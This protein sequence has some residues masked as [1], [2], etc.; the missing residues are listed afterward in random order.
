MFDW[1]TAAISSAGY[2]GVLFAMFLE[3]VFPPIPSELV[4]LFSGASAGR[5]ELNVILVFISALLGSL[6]GLL[7]WYY[8]ARWYGARRMASFA[9]RHGR[10]LTF[11][12]G[13]VRA[14]NEWFSKYGKVTVVIARF[15]PAIR[16]I[17]AVPAAVADMKILTFLCYALVGSI[18]YDGAFYV[19]GYLLGEDQAL[20]SW[21]NLGTAIVL[22]AVVIWYVYRV[23]TYKADPPQFS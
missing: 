1:I 17:I 18:V 4:M 3:N 12:G 21:I 13:E 22:L 11:T 20:Q 23:V 14:A 8:A 9:D 7:P 6:L 15:L 2:P 16:T 10:W 19:L 5:G